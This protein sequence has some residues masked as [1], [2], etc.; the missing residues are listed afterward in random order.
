MMVS[1]KL[2]TNLTSAQTSKVCFK[3]DFMAHVP[4]YIG[5]DQLYLGPQNTSVQEHLNFVQNWTVQNSMKI[6][7]SKINNVIFSRC[8][9]NF[10]TRLTLNAN[11]SFRKELNIFCLFSLQKMLETGKRTPQKCVIRPKEYCQL[12]IF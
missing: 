7:S 5:I 1:K 11:F 4:S 2:L 6:N 10:A 9:E 8:Q 12:Y 3:Y